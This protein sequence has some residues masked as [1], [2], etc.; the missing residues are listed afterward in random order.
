MNQIYFLTV[1]LLV[2]LLCIMVLLIHK[3]SFID[4]KVDHYLFILSNEYHSHVNSIKKKSRIGYPNMEIKKLFKYV[5][6]INRVD[7]QQLMLNYVQTNN[8]DE[9]DILLYEDMHYDKNKYILNYYS[10]SYT[11][12]NNLSKFKFGVYNYKN[13]S[14]LLLITNNVIDDQLLF[15]QKVT[16]DPNYNFVIEVNIDGVFKERTLSTNEI[17][18]NGN[19]LNG[20]EVKIGDSILIR[21][22]VNKHIEGEYIVVKKTNSNIVLHMYVNVPNKYYKCFSTFPN[23]KPHLVSKTQCIHDDKDNIWDHKCRRNIECPA[24]DD[25]KAICDHGFCKIPYYKN[26]ISFRKYK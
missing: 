1:L 8:I 15:H 10:D 21:K 14:Y 19:T 11:L 7:E 9:V 23:V 24:F 3:E 18:L 22:Q 17:K 4:M 26:Q 25:Q 6:E 13:N 20:L 2:L 5:L 16:F 12:H